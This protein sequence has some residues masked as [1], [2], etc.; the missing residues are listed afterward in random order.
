M[1]HLAVA[2]PLLFLPIQLAVRA[3]EPLGMTRALHTASVT[4]GQF[5]PASTS[6]Q[7]SVSAPEAQCYYP[8]C[9]QHVVLALRIRGALKAKCCESRNG[10]P[11]VM[12]ILDAHATGIPTP[13]TAHRRDAGSKSGFRSTHA[14]SAKPPRDRGDDGL[15]HKLPTH[16]NTPS[17][18]RERMGISPLAQSLRSPVWARTGRVSVGHRLAPILISESALACS[19]HCPPLSDPGI[20]SMDA[21]QIKAR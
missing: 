15:V 13:S 16:H 12:A 2:G 7:T 9:Q 1:P 4:R 5:I 11:T 18:G 19:S 21:L 17:G 3:S 20:V 14:A 10:T 8:Y 6:G